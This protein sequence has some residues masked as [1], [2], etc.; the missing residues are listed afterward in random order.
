MCLNKANYRKD[1]VKQCLI[2]LR[3]VLDVDASWSNICSDQQF[4]VTISQISQSLKLER[5]SV[6]YINHSGFINSPVHDPLVH[7]LRE[8][9]GSQFRANST[10]L[11]PGQ[12]QS[13]GR[14]K[15]WLCLQDRD[16]EWNPE[17][18]RTIIRQKSKS[19]RLATSYPLAFVLFVQNFNV[20]SDGVNSCQI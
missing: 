13:F 3:N 18:K 14:Q 5:V 11:R 16:L 8:C 10:R 1:R 19:F 20:L 7:D 17:A 2:D 15:R 6:N 4:D 12:P 9:I